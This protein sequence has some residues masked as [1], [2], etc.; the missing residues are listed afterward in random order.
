LGLGLIIASALKRSAPKK[1]HFLEMS[2][3][4]STNFINLDIGI[5]KAIANWY[6][7]AKEGF[8]SPSFNELIKVR[9]S[10]D[11]NPSCY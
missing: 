2:I 11:S 3:S 5:S 7:V 8:F 10:S 6:M 1:F 4:F 9:L